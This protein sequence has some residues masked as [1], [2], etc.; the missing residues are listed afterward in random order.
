MISK[1]PDRAAA[2]SQATMASLLAGPTGRFSRG[3]RRGSDPSR[4]AEA[5]TRSDQRLPPPR[6]ACQGRPPRLAPPSGARK[7]SIR[8]GALRVLREAGVEVVYLGNRLPVERYE[9]TVSQLAVLSCRNAM[10]ALR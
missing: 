8:L 10:T 4:R 6:Q 9:R 2:K 5:S 3:M 7:R 1:L